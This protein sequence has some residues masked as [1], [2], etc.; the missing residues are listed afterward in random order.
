MLHN[1][2]HGFREGRGMGMATLESNLD[3]Q[4]LGLVQETLFQVFLDFRKAY[5]LLDWEWC[6]E[7]LR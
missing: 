7:L 4:L 1:A 3:W 6:L 5:D 2:I